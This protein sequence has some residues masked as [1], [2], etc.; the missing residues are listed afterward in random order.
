MKRYFD[1]LIQ[2]LHENCGK[3]VDMNNWYNLT[4]FDIIGDLAFGESF[5]G[6]KNSG[7]HVKFL[8]LLTT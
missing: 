1:L 4:T 7:V 8:A 5:E 6:L 3:V 2:R